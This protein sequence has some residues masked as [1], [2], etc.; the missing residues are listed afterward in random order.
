MNRTVVIGASPNPGRYSYIATERLK[1]Y[2][3]EVFPIGIRDGHIGGDKII[4][5]RPLLENID[6]VTL[7]VGPRN[8]SSWFDYILQLAP[9]RVIF[10]PGTENE[11]LYRIL[12]ENG[13]KYEIACTLVLLSTGSYSAA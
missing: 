11:E 1:E 10:N 12:E 13:I 6:T 5:T 3:E 7:Y 8:Q 9:K 2:G 4:T